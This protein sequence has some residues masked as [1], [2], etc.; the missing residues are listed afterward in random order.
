LLDL[1]RKSNV[2]IGFETAALILALKCK[3][4]VY[5]SIPPGYGKLILPYKNIKEIRN[6]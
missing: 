1:L 3:K 2:V 6:I 5:S 4:K